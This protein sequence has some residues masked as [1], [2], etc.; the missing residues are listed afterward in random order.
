M[1]TLALGCG[2]LYIYYYLSHHLQK[3]LWKMD[4]DSDF[5]PYL[6]VFPASFSVYIRLCISLWCILDYN[7]VEKYL[8]IF[9]NIT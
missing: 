6:M 7:T 1:E 2:S 4:K 5:S 3:L 8:P 9:E